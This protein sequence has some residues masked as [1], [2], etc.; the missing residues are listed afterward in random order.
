MPPRHMIATNISASL[1]TSGRTSTQPGHPPYSWPGDTA[2]VDRPK[3][4]MV[5][6]HSG[7]EPDQP[8]GYFV[9]ESGGCLRFVPS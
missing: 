3:V 9:T 1:T 7:L 2:S 6:I 5:T 4:S 8:P